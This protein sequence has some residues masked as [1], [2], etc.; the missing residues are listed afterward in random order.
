MGNGIVIVKKHLQFNGS[1][2]I[3]TTFVANFK[4]STNLYDLE[5]NVHIFGR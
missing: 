1:I 5:A 4:T 2:E 3:N